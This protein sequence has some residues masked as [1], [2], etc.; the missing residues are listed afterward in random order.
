MRNLLLL[1]LII[2]VP[3]I[4]FSQQVQFSK[5]KQPNFY[6]GTV[7]VSPSTKLLATK[8]YSI[9]DIIVYETLTG[10]EIQRI[11]NKENTSAAYFIND[12]FLVRIN[13]RS[14]D[15][16]RISDN[17]IISNYSQDRLFFE[18][19]Y[20]VTSQLLAVTTTEGIILIDCSKKTLQ[21]SGMIPVSDHKNLSVTP[22][23]NFVAAKVKDSVYCWNVSTKA[24][25]SKIDA[26]KLI[27]FGLGEASIIV[28]N[29]SPFCY[30][31]YSFDG[32]LIQERKMP[33]I[34]EPYK[35]KIVPFSEGFTFSTYGKTVITY[36][37]GYQELLKTGLNFH[38]AFADWETAHLFTWNSRKIEITDLEGALQ[39]SIIAEQIANADIFPDK[40][41]SDIFHII[42]DSLI[43]IA[44]NEKVFKKISFE[45]K[46]ISTLSYVG[47][48]KVFQ[49]ENHNIKI[50]D[51]EK[52]TIISSFFHPSLPLDYATDNKD[53]WF[54]DRTENALYRYNLQTK[55]KDKLFTQAD[56]ITAITVSNNHV[57]IGDESG[58]LVELSIKVNERPTILQHHDVFTNPI[59]ALKSLKNGD[60][61]VG[62]YGR[63]VSIGKIFSNAADNKLYVGHNGFISSIETDKNED[64][65]YT[66]SNDQHIRLWDR[67]KGNVITDYSLDSVVANHIIDPKDGSFF[68]TGNNVLIGAVADT[69]LITK[70]KTLD[71]RIV[72]QSPNN[73]SPLKLAINQ[74]GT[75]L[76]AVDN[77]T[78][79][80]RDIKRGFLLNEISVGKDPLN[81]ITFSNDGSMLAIAAAEYIYTFDPYTGNLIRKIDLSKLSRAG[82]WASGMDALFKRS[83]HDIEA[84]QN[85]FVAFNTHGWHQPMVIHKNSGLRLFEL[86]FNADDRY[87][88]QI[89]DFKVTPDGKW[90]ATYGTNYIKLFSAEKTTILKYAFSRSNPNKFI[91]NYSD[92]L[93]FSPDGKFL[94][95]VDIETN[96]K[97][98]TIVDLLTGKMV[99]QHAGGL[100]ALG[101]N[102]DYYYA[103]NE[104]TLTK[105]NIFNERQEQLE[106]E[107][108]QFRNTGINNIVFNSLQ[109]IVAVSD[110]WGNIRVIDGRSGKAIT[111]L[112]RM[113][114]YNYTALLSP[115][116]QTL[117]FNNKW[118]MYTVDMNSLKRESLPANNYP[119]SGAFSPDGKTVYFRD[120]QMILS[121]NLHSQSLDT[122]Y[123][124]EELKR[125]AGL[126]ISSD[127][128]NLIIY[129]TT[130]D[131]TLVEIQKKIPW[132]SFNRFNFKGGDGFIIKDIISKQGHNYLK[133]IFIKTD[134]SN[135]VLQYALLSTDQEFTKQ[136]LSPEISLQRGVQGQF[137][138][139]VFEADAKVFEISPSGKYLAFMKDLELYIIDTK[140]KD[141][142][143]NRDNS[144]ISSIKKGLFDKDEKYFIIG[145][146]DGYVE[147][148][149][150]TKKT[151]D[152]NTAF[153]GLTQLL[154]F[155]GNDMSIESIQLEGNKLLLKGGNSFLSVYNLENNK[156]TKMLDMAF[157]RGTDQVYINNE[158]YYYASKDA[159]NY[160]AY[161]RGND[162]LSLDLTDLKYNRPDKL[163]RSSGS[164]DTHLITAYHNAYI[165]RLKKN[166]IDSTWHPKFEEIP[167]CKLVNATAIP[168]DMSEPAVS[169]KLSATAVKG[170]LKSLNVWVNN[171]PLF[172]KSGSTISPNLALDTTVILT[173]S[174]GL[175]KIEYAVKNNAGMESV[176]T[177]LY[178]RH[179]PITVPKEKVYFIGI[180]IDRFADNQYNLQYSAKD[181]RDLTTKFKSKFG[182]KII[183]DTLFNENVTVQ[184][185]K[186]LKEKLL[187]TSVND[188]VIV[189][190]SGHG[191]LS[192][193]YDYYLSTYSIN[194]TDPTINGLAY[195]ELENLL[196]GI[197]ARKK[198][199]LIDACHS[200]EVDKEEGI[201]MDSTAA[202]IGL[203][204]GLTIKPTKNNQKLGLS[205]SF[206]LMQNLF[207]NLGNS[208]GTTIISAAAGN[209]YA[210]E[211][212]DLRNGVFTYCLIEAME[213]NEPMKVSELKNR[214]AERVL[215]IT[216]GLQKPTS[217]NETLAVD[218]NIW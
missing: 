56:L 112:N 22:S 191:L 88:N 81:G 207:V 59:T 49:L 216:K 181:I 178:V 202:A 104:E 153:S 111:E 78:V 180:G 101:N 11:S 65:V 38:S 62:S 139:F 135:S 155:K 201:S 204:K 188:K 3:N 46:F 163:L 47:K 16:I 98:I 212:G 118:G 85:A 164:N 169:L 29:K 71:E 57:Y 73:N 89:Y 41:D 42:S 53:L 187:K 128:R 119:F 90:F 13:T 12:S 193:D 30:K 183:I 124:N 217:R 1:V 8:P 60:L 141:T 19:D 157:I 94:A 84:Y 143:F 176:R 87:D 92:H 106:Y 34:P 140:T 218:W 206:E 167:E 152:R 20:A 199:M 23:G 146:E 97:K 2:A 44:S 80:V 72:L 137:E 179:T 50:Y 170:K 154:H 26:S 126:S 148:Y 66:T 121:K 189:S 28:L 172:G 116:K 117:L 149:D 134:N 63:F 31:K 109:N 131:I 24:L 161:K 130:E 96:R 70:W 82:T 151:D 33:L 35:T 200:G 18:D 127:G 182:D 210:L 174:A 10:K 40:A 120:K 48:W 25:T 69:Q 159:L 142:I 14:V 125:F 132:F 129:S 103:E 177:P 86:F 162:F 175:N 45:S 173:L 107:W 160:V 75:L 67:L 185:I 214:L 55:Q 136:P 165:K 17:A 27:S 211:R 52:R 158:G 209:Q 123:R 108:Y 43:T 32:K 205:N 76:A 21:L 138:K 114:Q 4:C 147:V 100:I 64:I 36:P 133:G 83:I 203:K 79:K 61:L 105:A 150:L 113:D 68:F 192:K 37:T 5:A 186:S 74:Q 51:P 198:L 197:P 184:K 166:L 110:V 58:N 156:E 171:V 54:I 95:W 145:T 168:Y 77:N 39:S 195:D 9:N 215:E 99:K 115:D 144:F 190:Y 91:S 208:T 122:I 213:K 6:F 196:D 93:S 194:F 15:I 7:S 102:G